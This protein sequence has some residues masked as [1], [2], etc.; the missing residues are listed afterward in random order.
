MNR[1]LVG[2]HFLALGKSFLNYFFTEIYKY[3]THFV[4]KEF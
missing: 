2:L 3:H 1:V 4:E